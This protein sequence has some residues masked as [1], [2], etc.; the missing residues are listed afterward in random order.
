ML[1]NFTSRVPEGLTGLDRGIRNQKKTRQ[2][3]AAAYYAVRRA[4]FVSSSTSGNKEVVSVGLA[5]L[6]NA[7]RPFY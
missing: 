1:F 6:D 3:G 2:L 7:V 4:I 5:P